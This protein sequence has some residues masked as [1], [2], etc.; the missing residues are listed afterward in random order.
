VNILSIFLLLEILGF[1]SIWGAVAFLDY[2]YPIKDIRIE[3]IP[4]PVLPDG[5]PPE[6]MT[7]SNAVLD[8]L[9]D[10]LLIYN[11]SSPIQMGINCGSVIAFGHYWY[12]ENASMQKSGESTEIEGVP[13][14]TN[15]T[16]GLT[17]TGSMG[18]S[19]VPDFTARLPITADDIHHWINIS[20][21]MDVCH[22]IWAGTNYLE[23][24]TTFYGDAGLFVV[25][26][27]DIQLKNEYLQER[28]EYLQKV[29]DAQQKNE[30]NMGWLKTGIPVGLAWGF[31]GAPLVSV[32]YRAYAGRRA[33]GA[34]YPRT[35]R[36][37]EEDTTYCKCKVTRSSQLLIFA[38]F[39][40]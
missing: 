38:F 35:A 6:L 7:L 23:T 15:K 33:R 18:D 20:A 12:G 26:P 27:E 10:G 8:P 2:A 11:G 40:F 34:G 17:I 28:N 29:E 16:W 22:P 14:H 36:G 25:K 37:Y 5:T 24:S 3:D 21:K 13:T 19:V 31:L 32:L 1:V 9:S 30:N 39:Q 4:E